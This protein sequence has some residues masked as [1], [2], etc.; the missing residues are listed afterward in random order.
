MLDVVRPL[1]VCY[2]ASHHHRATTTRLDDGRKAYQSQQYKK[3][4]AKDLKG[5]DD[6]DELCDDKKLK[7][8]KARIAAKFS[9][10]V[11]VLSESELDCCWCQA[12]GNC[13]VLKDRKQYAAFTFGKMKLHMQKQ[14]AAQYRSLPLSKHK[15]K[16]KK[17]P[18][19][20][21]GGDK[22][23]GKQVEEEKV[24]EKKVDREKACSKRAMKQ[25]NLSSF[26]GSPVSGNHNVARGS[27]EAGNVA[28]GTKEE[29]Y[30]KAE[31]SESSDAVT[32]D[33][34][35]LTAGSPAQVCFIKPAIGW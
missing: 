5:E 18:A 6:D 22:S 10:H 9:G 1:V 24:Q 19:E 29:N 4:K 21:D 34:P 20:Q 25:S 7:E 11:V 12:E 33:S 14:H 28:R 26:F 17:A 13:M 30:G 32:N 35:S 2:H 23:S 27:K 8:F 3:R 16:K 15:R 31:S